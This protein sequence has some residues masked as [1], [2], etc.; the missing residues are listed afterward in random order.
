MPRLEAFASADDLA[1]D[2]MPGTSGSFGR[3]EL[4]VDDVQVGPAHAARADPQQHLAVVRASGSGSSARRSG[5][6]GASS[7]IARIGRTIDSVGP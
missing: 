4:A 7:T 6:R 5:V 2:L 1:D 3:V